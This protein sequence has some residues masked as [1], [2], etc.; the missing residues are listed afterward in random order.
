MQVKAKI[1]LLY[2]GE[3]YAAGKIFEMDEC[4]AAINEKYNRVDIIGGAVETD[5]EIGEEVVEGLPPLQTKG[6]KK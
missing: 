4:T 5:S 6:K 3:V 2:K 1:N